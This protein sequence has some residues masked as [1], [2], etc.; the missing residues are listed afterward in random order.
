M[1]DQGPTDL[2]HVFSHDTETNTYYWQ[3]ALLLLAD[4]SEQKNPDRQ[5]AT[6]PVPDA[7]FMDIVL[8]P[9]P[10]SPVATYAAKKTAPPSA[11]T[12]ITTTACHSV[13]FS[14]LPLTTTLDKPNVLNTQRKLLYQPPKPLS[15]LSY[16]DVYKRQIISCQLLRKWMIRVSMY[17]HISDSRLSM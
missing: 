12:L 10:T 3:K 5:N 11:L 7:T 4:I 8:P 1:L 2:I 16:K 9:A 14:T 13:P 15:Y 6:S 17:C